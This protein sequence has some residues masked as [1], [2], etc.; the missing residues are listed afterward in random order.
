MLCKFRKKQYQQSVILNLYQQ[1]VSVILNLQQ[2]SVILILYQH[3][4]YFFTCIPKWSKTNG[5][6]KSK[7][8][9]NA[10]DGE[11]CSGVQ[12]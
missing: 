3:F 12:Y 4:F 5:F 9:S 11:E 8:I 1:S 6:K 10:L 2:Q 7:Y